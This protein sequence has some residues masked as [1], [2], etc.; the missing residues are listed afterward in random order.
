MKFIMRLSLLL[1]LGW[2][3]FG[4]AP[5]F[6]SG[7]VKPH[8]LHTADTNKYIRVLSPLGKVRWKLGS[9]QKIEWESN[10]TDSV[11]IDLFRD[12]EFVG[13]IEP[14]AFNLGGGRKNTL[15]WKVPVEMPEGKTYRLMLS[16]VTQNN[17]RQSS[18]LFSIDK[19]GVKI[20]KWIWIGLGAVV[21]GAAG[22]FIYQAT[23]P[24]KEFILPDPP[25]P[26]E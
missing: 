23:R 3:A 18:D 7:W 11:K 21:V 20:S 1:V 8:T 5:S 19:G 24:R 14:D 25:D 16:H 4:T 22:F 15:V 10:F 12:A 9:T 26:G 13:N 17:V 6:A 2:L